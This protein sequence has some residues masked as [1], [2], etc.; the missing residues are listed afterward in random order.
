MLTCKLLVIK[1]GLLAS[2]EV[3][4]VA[5][6]IDLVFADDSRRF[7]SYHSNSTQTSQQFI[8]AAM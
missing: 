8:T 3:K 2:Q 1:A 5:E 6:D 7:S 4:V